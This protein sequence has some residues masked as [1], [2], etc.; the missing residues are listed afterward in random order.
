M[1]LRILKRLFS[2]GEAEFALNLTLIPES[3]KVIAW[4]ANISKK[5]ACKRLESMARKGLIIKMSPKIG[6]P[7]YLAAQFVIGIWELQVE[8]L[9]PGLAADMEEYSLALFDEAWKRPQLR[10]VPVGRSVRANLEVATYERAEKI[11]EKRKK[12][13]VSPCI[14]LRERKLA[15]KGCGKPEFSCLSFDSTAQMVVERGYGRFVEKQAVLNLLEKADESGLVLQPGISRKTDFLC[16]CCGCCCGVLRALKQ[17]SKPA[18]HVSSPFSAAS[19]PE[20]CI[21]C[22]ICLDRCQM[23]A[24]RFEYGAAFPDPNRC[25]GCGLCVSKCPTGALN[26]ERKSDITQK[27][28]RNIASALIAH[29]KARGKLGPGQM[30]RMIMKS[31]RDKAAAGLGPSPE[32]RSR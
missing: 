9:T 14:C 4:R 12:Y 6:K 25:I 8:R 5:E 13:A 15:G 29:G 31:A 20:K 30:T 28:P 21:G 17:F 7:L 22:Q 27:I 23:D 1:E 11:V 32:K 24:L 16:C 18:E 2:P 26:L 3:A 19:N 10:T